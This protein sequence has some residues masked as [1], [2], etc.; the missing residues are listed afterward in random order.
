MMVAVNVVG[1]LLGSNSLYTGDESRESRLFRLED[2]R[3]VMTDT[4][5]AS[6]DLKPAG[7]SPG[8]W[9]RQESVA[10]LLDPASGDCAAGPA[11]PPQPWFDEGVD[12]RDPECAAQLEEQ[13][14]SILVAEREAP[15]SARLAAQ[16][17]VTALSE[18]DASWASLSVWCPSGVTYGFRLGRGGATCVLRLVECRTK[19]R[20]STWTPGIE[21]RPLPACAC[22]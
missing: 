12:L 11:H 5:R 6:G 1:L 14:A 3:L 8:Y 17:N 20:R 10:L 19:N 4:H 2:G 21:E 9:A 13:V 16:E 15:E 22:N 18:S 7:Q